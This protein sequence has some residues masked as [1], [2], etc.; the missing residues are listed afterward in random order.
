M[1]AGMKKRRAQLNRGSGNRAQTEGQT[2][3]SY[4]VGAL[5]I[6]NRLIE[7]MRLPV[8]SREFLVVDKRCTI[9]TV[10]GVLLLLKNDLL[11]CEP[12]YGFSVW[13]RGAVPALWWCHWW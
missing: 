13:A 2:L 6:L 8:F 11:S 5:P 9:S 1:F 7:R 12:I 10:T 3:V 4:D